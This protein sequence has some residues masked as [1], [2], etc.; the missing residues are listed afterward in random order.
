MRQV[1]AIWVS[2]FCTAAGF[3]MHYKYNKCNKQYITSR[4]THTSKLAQQNVVNHSILS[5]KI[6][7]DLF[8]RPEEGRSI[9]WGYPHILHSHDRSGG[10]QADSLSSLGLPP[11]IWDAQI[12]FLGG[13]HSH[14]HYG[15]A[16]LRFL[17][18]K[19]ADLVRMVKWI[20]P[21]LFL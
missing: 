18:F 5:K 21:G 4:I 2:V 15:I 8:Q 13:V 10:H 17:R 16:T 1:T 7:L 9:R 11:W 6:Y 12:R 3:T 14:F 20:I 19:E